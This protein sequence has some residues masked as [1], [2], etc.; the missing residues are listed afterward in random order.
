[1]DKT[2]AGYFAE[3]AEGKIVREGYKK[4][5]DMNG[6]VRMYN[7]EGKLEHIYTY[8]L[9]EANGYEAEYDSATGNILA[10]GIN[11]SGM[12][13]GEWKRYKDGKVVGTD[14]YVN[15]DKQ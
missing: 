15:G 11:K 10:S 4:G 1:M 7:E 2:K 14:T 3:K 5:D 13:D 9:N 12:R 6:E 8:V